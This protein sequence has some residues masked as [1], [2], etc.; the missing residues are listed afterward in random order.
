METSGAIDNIFKVA[1][2]LKNEKNIQWTIIGTGRKLE[3]IK[4]KST[5]RCQWSC[6]AFPIGGPIGF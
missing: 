1:R 3:E 4:R 2:E 6:R 5:E